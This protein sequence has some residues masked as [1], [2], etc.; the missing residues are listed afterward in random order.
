MFWEVVA[1]LCVLC[2]SHWYLWNSRFNEGLVQGAEVALDELEKEELIKVD[3]D[4]K[5]WQWDL[6]L[7][8]RKDRK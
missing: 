1:L 6:Y 7:Q 5:I 8:R 4:G 3:G 2:F